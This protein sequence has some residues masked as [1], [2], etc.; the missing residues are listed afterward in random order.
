MSDAVLPGLPPDAFGSEPLGTSEGTVPPPSGPSVDPSKGAAEPGAAREGIVAV[1][2]KRG[3]GR[4]PGSKNKP[5]DGPKD[6]GA[7]SSSSSSPPPPP[8]PPP[9]TVTGE[10]CAEVLTILFAGYGFVRGLDMAT[11]GIPP[12][13]CERVRLAWTPPPEA[14]SRLGGR[15]AALVNKYN[16]LG[17]FKD[18]ILFAGAVAA[19]VS[20]CLMAEAS[21]AEA[22]NAAGSPKRGDPKP[23][24][25]A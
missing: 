16:L 14:L 6:E 18:E 10:E 7:S 1:A 2:A 21:V 9:E 15:T 8:P 4:P 13:F 20:G 11:K 22:Y 23:S 3:R 25:P 5:K 19:T 12:E 24:A 17:R